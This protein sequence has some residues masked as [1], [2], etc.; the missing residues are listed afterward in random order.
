MSLREKT[1]SGAKW[2]AIATGTTLSPV[3]VGQSQPPESD[4]ISVRSF[5]LEKKI[6]HKRLGWEVWIGIVWVNGGGGV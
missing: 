5:S 4:R 2:S 1:I 3:R 6:S